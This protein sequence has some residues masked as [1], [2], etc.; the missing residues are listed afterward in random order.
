[1]T[2]TEQYEVRG[3]ERINGKYKTLL[4]IHIGQPAVAIKLLKWLQAQLPEYF[5]KLVK[6]TETKREK[7]IN[8]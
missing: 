6:V 2:K 5:F 8:L 4:T 1:M 7:E 3:G